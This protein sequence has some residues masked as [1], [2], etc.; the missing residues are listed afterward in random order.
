MIMLL[1]IGPASPAGPWFPGAPG[2]PMG[3]SRPGGPRIVETRKVIVFVLVS[4][5]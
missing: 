1:P 3:P 5:K 4:K 2:G